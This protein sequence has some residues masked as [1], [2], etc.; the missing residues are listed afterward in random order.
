[1]SRNRDKHLDYRVDIYAL[2]DP[3]NNELFYIGKTRCGMKKRL[4]LHVCSARK[5]KPTLTCQRIRGILARGAYPQIVTVAVTNAKQW[6]IV[7]DI[8]IKTYIKAGFHLTNMISGGGG[9]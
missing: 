7:E 2:I 1:M 9:E 4:H 3:T 6:H 5:G 8:Y